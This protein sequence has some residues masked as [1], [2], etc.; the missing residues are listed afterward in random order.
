MGIEAKGA[1]QSFRN[2]VWRP[3]V[4]GLWLKTTFSL[5]LDTDIHQP[6]MPQTSQTHLTQ[7]TPLR[8]HQFPT[9]AITPPRTLP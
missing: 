6:Q 5:V 9:S 7:P 1:N 4:M 2:Q 8:A 3:Q